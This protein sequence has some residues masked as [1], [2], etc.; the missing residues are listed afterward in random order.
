MRGTEEKPTI[1]RPVYNGDHHVVNTLLQDSLI[2][3]GNSGLK[4]EYRPFC[5][6]VLLFGLGRSERRDLDTAPTSNDERTSNWLVR[7]VCSS[8]SPN[9]IF[10]NTTSTGIDKALIV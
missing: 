10:T 5:R 8:A 7:R 6:M 4:D 2:F 9:K 3:R 1:G